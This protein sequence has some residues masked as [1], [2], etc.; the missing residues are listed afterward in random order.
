ME[1]YVVLRKAGPA[2]VSTKPVR[3]QPYW[4]EHAEFIDRLFEAGK[5]MLA[6]PFSDGNGALLIVKTE[7]E[8]EAK[9]I[10]DDDPWVIQDIQDRGEVRRW[11]IFLNEF[12]KA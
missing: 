4:D 6:G 2:W 9:T 3:E 7:T 5:I 10:F 1:T 8:E 11:Q 12:T